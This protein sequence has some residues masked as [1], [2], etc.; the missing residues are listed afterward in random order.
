MKKILALILALCLVLSTVGTVA[1]ASEAVDTWD[2]TAD[3]T[4]YNDADTEFTLT[5]AEQLAG[6][7]V[8]VNGGNSF[9]GKTVKLGADLD[10]SG[11]AWTPIGTSNYDKTPTTADVKMFAGNFDGGNHTITGLTSDGYVPAATETGSTEYSF[12]LFGY[13]YGSNFSNIKLADVAIDC[14]T[15]TNSDGVDVYGSGIAA[16]IGYYFPA[17]DKTVEIKNCHVLSGTVKASN[18]MGGLIGHMDSQLSQPKV[19]ITIENCSNAADVT[20][21]A[22]EAGGILGLMNS[23]REG[24]SFHSISD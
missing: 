23:A 21:E 10:I 1:L 15:R 11:T 16:L 9:S 12:G 2:G 20:T 24:I 18:N 8:L 14:G 6:L 19:D 13:V 5:T 7:A 17:N 22:R 3:T 4:W